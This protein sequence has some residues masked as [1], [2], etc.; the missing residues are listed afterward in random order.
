MSDSAKQVRAAN[1][2]VRALRSGEGSASKRADPHLSPEV[3]ATV[4]NTEISGKDA[5]LAHIT[6]IWP[7]TPV[8]QL[9]AW[10]DPSVDGDVVTIEAEFPAFGAGAQR[11]TLTFSFNADDHI[12]SVSEAYQSGPRP[13]PQ[14]ELPMVARG[15]INSALANGTPIVVAYTGEDGSPQLSL[16]GSTVVYSPTQLA[17]WLRSAEGGLNRAMATNPKISMLYRDSRT[18]STLIIKGTGRIENDP[19]IRDEIF[20]LTPEVEQMHDPDRNGAALIIDLTE[21]RGGTPRG[22]VNVQI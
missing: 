7:N 3:V 11:A 16:R 20:D 18:R 19:A 15:M 21:V 6:G 5:V 12:I 13:D 17:I 8:Y 4:G 14:K 22:E 1:A 2:Y 10:G 9:G